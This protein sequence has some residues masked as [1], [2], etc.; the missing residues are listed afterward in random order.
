MFKTARPPSF[1]T[2]V[3]QPLIR[4][5]QQLR[6]LLDLPQTRELAET[7]LSR[8]ETRPPQTQNFPSANHPRLG[9]ASLQR[10]LDAKPAEGDSVSDRGS[11]GSGLVFSAAR[12]RAL[13]AEARESARKR[14]TEAGWT[15]TMLA[16]QE[17]RRKEG[18]IDAIEQHRLDL[19]KAYDEQRRASALEVE[20]DARRKD[21]LFKEQREEVERRAEAK[22]RARAARIERERA[23][24]REEKELEAAEIA[25][26]KAAMVAEAEGQLEELDRRIRAVQDRT[27]VDR[28]KRQD[29]STAVLD[30]GEPALGEEESVEKPYE[31]PEVEFSSHLPGRRQRDGHTPRT[32]VDEERTE[33][34]TVESSG[35][36]LDRIPQEGDDSLHVKRGLEQVLG[37]KVPGGDKLEGEA[38]SGRSADDRINLEEWY[39]LALFETSESGLFGSEAGGSSE[40]LSATPGAGETES[41]GAAQ[42]LGEGV[43]LSAERPGE[44]SLLLGLRQTRDGQE[45]KARK[46]EERVEPGQG[47]DVSAILAGLVSDLEGGQ[48]GPA[49]GEAV[50]EHKE[51]DTG[52]AQL[53]SKWGPPQDPTHAAGVARDGLDAL[54]S[55]GEAARKGRQMEG[56]EM[57]DVMAGGFDGFRPLPPAERKDADSGTDLASS[58]TLARWG[59][60]ADPFPA[61]GMSTKD[62]GDSFAAQDFRFGGGIDFRGRGSEPK[63]EH[64]GNPSFETGPEE[65]TAGP[66]QVAEQTPHAGHPVE[67]SG[68]EYWSDSGMPNDQH[69]RVLS[70]ETSHQALAFLSPI[71]SASGAP[72]PFDYSPTALSTPVS[73]H[74]DLS[75]ALASSTGVS[76]GPKRSPPVA[77]T[78]PKPSGRPRDPPDDDSDAPLSVVMGVCVVQEILAQY[79]CVS[80]CC[81][82]VFQE[83]LALPAHCAALR[84]YLFM[85]AGDFADAFM[86][87]LLSQVRESRPL[88]EG[89]GGPVNPQAAT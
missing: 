79:R 32:E 21:A 31:G 85:L 44:T 28:S 65:R 4:A 48:S 63:G 87:A 12:L 69:P 53:N 81:V 7:I 86:S 73:A 29:I 19:A 52:D 67:D 1:L 37:E 84:R 49:V 56:R 33:L 78:Q 66:P 15:L 42:R 5:G 64:D 74:P 11:V 38:E 17:R 45:L 75:A 36:L 61:A 70:S 60:T 2:A 72:E 59:S 77:P 47:D 71:P 30:G 80:A 51:F 58:A 82:R 18:N 6:V 9:A 10:L 62:L 54:G 88:T 23:M 39:R 68:R 43:A 16:M 25:R 24:L 35:R 41:P 26:V 34:R 8:P 76:P 27:A 55:A 20:K 50:P 46:E 13:A 89:V 22:R 3:W 57:R 83:E 14:E 40:G